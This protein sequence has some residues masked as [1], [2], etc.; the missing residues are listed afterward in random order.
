MPVTILHMLI[1]EQIF[2]Q[3]ALEKFEKTEYSKTP[4]LEC[5]KMYSKFGVYSKIGVIYEV[6]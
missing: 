2:L 6:F 3:G 1:F 4:I 5:Q